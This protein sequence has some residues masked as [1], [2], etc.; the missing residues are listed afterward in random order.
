MSVDEGVYWIRN[1]RW[2]NKVLDLSGGNLGQGTSVLNFDRKET[3]NMLLN[4][5]WLVE[6]FQNH[7]KYIIRSVHSN[8]V[9]NLGSSASGTRICCW[10]QNG[11]TNQQWQIEW[12]KDVSGYV[13]A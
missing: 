12:V 5:L 13:D 8:L 1:L 11:R 6:R 4:Q 3:F 7:H 2:T 9:L 10:N